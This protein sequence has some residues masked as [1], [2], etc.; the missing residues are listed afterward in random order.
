LQEVNSARIACLGNNLTCLS[1]GALAV[2]Y[3]IGLQT[4]TH[5]M[6]LIEL[7]CHLQA[8]LLDESLGIEIESEGVRV[9][10]TS[11]GMRESTREGKH[12][13]MI[14]RGGFKTSAT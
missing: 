5:Q 1:E 14:V 12:V 7:A 11:L 3:A 13:L 8:E 10:Q 4:P 2:T 6:L 9:M